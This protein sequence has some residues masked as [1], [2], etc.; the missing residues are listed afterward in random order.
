M[1]TTPTL[2]DAAQAVLRAHLDN[3][4][5][6]PCDEHNDAVRVKSCSPEVQA[7]YAALAAPTDALAEP[8]EWQHRMGP[9]D[10]WNE[11]TKEFHDWVLRAPQEWPGSEVRALVPATQLQ[12]AVARALE[13]AACLCDQLGRNWWGMRLGTGSENIRM[14]LHS[15]VHGAEQCA[16]AIRAKGQ[17]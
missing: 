2:R 3:V 8:V 16:A 6:H 9:T 4:D 11:C 7:L 17:Q 15:K 10:S 5:V 14:H 13:D 12:Q 1:T